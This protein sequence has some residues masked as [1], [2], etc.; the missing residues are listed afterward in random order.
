MAKIDTPLN[1]TQLGVGPVF[2]SCPPSSGLQRRQKFLPALLAQLSPCSSL[3]AASHLHGNRRARRTTALR[4][5]RGRRGGYLH[6][7]GCICSAR[8][9]DALCHLGLVGVV[10]ILLGAGQLVLYNVHFLDEDELLAAL[11][12]L[13]VSRPE[14][15]LLAGLQR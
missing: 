7:R 2:E 12:D 9:A 15:L 1:P 13:V 3:G 8:G 5:W 4:D 11:L 14:Y 6:L 10:D